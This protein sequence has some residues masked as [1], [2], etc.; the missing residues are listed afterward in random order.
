[1]GDSF[2]R[3]SK[4]WGQHDVKREVRIPS[5]QTTVAFLHNGR[6]QRKI[7][8]IITQGQHQPDDADHSQHPLPLYEEVEQYDHYGY[9]TEAQFRCQ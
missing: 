2:L 3:R 5:A 1:M 8:L 9:E 4:N 7:A 6:R